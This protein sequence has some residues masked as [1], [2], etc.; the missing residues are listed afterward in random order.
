VEGGATPELRRLVPNDFPLDFPGP[1]RLA[2]FF[3]ESRF[4]PIAKDSAGCGIGGAGTAVVPFPED[5]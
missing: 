1:F 2:V 5:G 3:V 4:L